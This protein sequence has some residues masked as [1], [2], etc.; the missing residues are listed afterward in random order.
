MLKKLFVGVF[1]VHCPRALT[2]VSKTFRLTLAL[3]VSSVWMTRRNAGQVNGS[4]P[5]CGRLVSCLGLVLL[6]FDF[7]SQVLAQTQIVNCDALVQSRKRGIGVNAMSPA[8]FEAVAPGV[9]W[10]YNWGATPLSLPSDVTMDFIPMAWDYKSSYQTDLTSYLAAG[11]RPWRVFALNEPN[12]TTQGNMTPAASA[13][14]FKQ[15]KAICDPYNIPVI[16]PHMA[17]GTAANQSI[18]A[19]DPIQGSNV[20]YTTEEPF[21]KAFFS[22]CS[23]NTPA[24]PAGISDHSYAGYGDLTY[25]TGL[26]HSDFPTQ[27]VWVTEFNTSASSDAAALANLIPSVDY[28]ERTP[29]IEGYSWFMSR[30]TGDPYNSL[31]SGSGILTAAGQ[32]YVQMPVHNANLYYRIPGRLQAERYV[33]INQM[34]IAPTTDANGLADMKSSAAGGSL[35]YNIQVDSAGNYPLNFRVAGATGQIKVYNG[36]TL[37]GTANIPTT[38]WSTV[39]TTVSLAAGTQTLH[40]VLSANAQQLNWMDFLATNGTPSI[41]S[42]LS[43][44]PGGNQ[45]VLNW[46]FSAGATSYN[47][48]SSTTN[49]GPYVTIASPT[50]TSYTN[51]GLALGTTYYYVVSAV[52]AAGE[53]TNSIQVGATTAFLPVNLALNQPTTVSSY[54]ASSPYCPG[55]YAVDGNPATRWASAWSDPQWIYVDLGAT[56]NI[57]EVVLNWQNSHATSFLIQVS[58]DANS[59]TTIYSTTTGPGGIQD[60]TGLSGLGRYVRMYGTVRYNGFGYSLWEFEVY[61]TVPTPTGLTATAVNTQV[62]LSWNASPGATSYNVKSAASSGGTYSTMANVTTTSYTNT[63]LFNGTTYY[64]EVSA[65]N[66]LSE[67]PN[68]TEVS[69]TPTNHPPVLAAIANQSILAGRTL[70]VT[71]SASDTDAPP[72]LLTYSLPGAPTGAS[73][74]TNSGL[75][76]WRPAIAQSPATQTV[77]VVVSDNGVPT[78]SA[79]QSFTITVTQ[80]AFP[81][82]NAVSITNGQFGFWINGDTGPDYTIQTSTD[83]TSWVPAFTSYSPALPCFWADTNS[84]SYPFVFYRVLLGP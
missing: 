20:T 78:M 53:S 11:N 50:T 27:T 65:L 9:S 59:W 6:A 75:F 42:S 5:T 80:P 61:G 15:V 58:S 35:D 32:A 60:L 46:S 22:Y 1:N 17:E 81:V 55:S 2:C 14:T 34:N 36:G 12:L 64:Y 83:L 51:T 8:D 56:Y 7:S 62:A 31:L 43:A 26:M 70:L 30:I 73:I 40:V 45:V 19:Y 28:C 68:S 67:S 57:T 4:Y 23:S 33:T 69:A 39:S 49:G 21:L 63:G 24:T 18:T 74:D 16:A 37:L 41:P 76:T 82:L 72:Q 13:T 25:W 79:T 84:M 66:S 47:V 52:N 44:T 3:F 77:A 54:Q 29:W 48:K 38:S 10:Y 71:N